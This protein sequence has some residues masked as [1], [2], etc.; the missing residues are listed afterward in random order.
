MLGDAIIEEITKFSNDP[1]VALAATERSKCRT[2]ASKIAPAFDEL[3]RTNEL[4]DITP[5]DFTQLLAAAAHA[6]DIPPVGT[7]NDWLQI[8]GRLHTKCNGDLHINTLKE[9]AVRLHR[10]LWTS[11]RSRLKNDFATDGRAYAALQLSFMSEALRSLHDLSEQG[12]LTNAQL[13]ELR[14][15]KEQQ[16]DPKIAALLAMLA[17]DNTTLATQFRADFT[18]LNGE[19]AVHFQR[20]SVQLQRIETKLDQRNDAV[21]DKLLAR[22]SE[23]AQEKGRLRAELEAALQR[24]AEAEAKGNI[25]AGDTLTQL[26]KDGDPKPLGAF[27]DQ[28]LAATQTDLLALLRERLAVAYISGEIERATECAHQILATLP[29]DLFAINEL[30]H[31]YRLRG[32]LEAASKQ[33]RRLLELAPDDE[34]SRAIALGNLGLIYRTQGKLAEAEQFHRDA[35][36]IN[37]KLGSLAG[38]ASALAN[39]GLIAEDRGNLVEARRLWTEARELFARVGAEP[40]VKQGESWLAGLPE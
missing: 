18:Q 36:A 31:I 21:V 27:L 1:Q 19:L 33:Y 32:D 34:S 2:F 37:L 9:I 24:L 35:L 12:Q 28:Q 14:T 15:A 39:L 25:S 40:R 10:N 7:V 3:M 5:P 11:I 38:Q 22:I 20:L 29:N 13:T 16:A 23:E 6:H 30:G 17:Q 8:V 4:P 26:R